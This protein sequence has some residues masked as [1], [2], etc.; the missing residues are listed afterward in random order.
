MNCY[1]DNFQACRRIG[2]GKDFRFHC[3]CWLLSRIRRY[4]E[5]DTRMKMIMLALLPLLT[6]LGGCMSALQ[7]AADRRD[8]RIHAL[9]NGGNAEAQY[10]VGMFFN[11]GMGGMTRDPRVAFEW[12]GKAAAGG[13]ALGAY[14]VG[15]YYA[16]QF[17]GTV[18]VDQ[19]KALT[20]KL[21]AANAG[22]ALAQ[23]DVGIIY[24]NRKD[25]SQSERW[26]KLAGAQG[27]S[28]SNNALSTLYT[29]DEPGMKNLQLAY[30]RFKLAS[31]NARNEV[32]PSA[33][34]SLTRL[35]EKLPAADLEAAEK[36]VDGFVPA[37]SQLTL[38]AFNMR[39]RINT[40]LIAAQEAKVAA[41][42]AKLSAAVV[43]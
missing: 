25:Y 41:R 31:R 36:F 12:F 30:A 34:D 7:A 18:E 35:A 19:E 43:K 26:W 5:M 40:L 13:D 20:H 10:H 4:A 2:A 9:A 11:N 37:P 22:Y 28:P 1:A 6:M 38:D 14:K 42:E 32:S 21:V 15:C 16:G 29:K 39:K 24:F 3:N 27:F 33:V 17:P 23:H 8:E